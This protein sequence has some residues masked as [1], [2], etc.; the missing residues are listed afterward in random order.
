MNLKV[1]RVG[2]K[3]WSGAQAD[4]DRIVTIWRDCFAAYQGPYLFGKPCMADA[5]YA[6]VVKR[7]LTY[8]VHLDDSCTAYCERIMALPEMVEW[9]AAAL[10]EPNELEELDMEF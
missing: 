8:D 4:I 3:A 7:F 1:K 5:M 6:P 9:C 10:R 2:F